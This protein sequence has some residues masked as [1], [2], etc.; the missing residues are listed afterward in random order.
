MHDLAGRGVLK[1]VELGRLTHGEIGQ[2]TL[3]QRRVQPQHLPGRDDPVAPER[4]REPRHSRIRI[5]PGRQVGGQQGDVGPRLVQPVV[6]ARTARPPERGPPA[7]PNAHGQPRLYGVD[8]VSRLVRRVAPV[9]PAFDIEVAAL[10]L[11][12]AEH[13]LGP[14]AAQPGGRFGKGQTTGPSHRVQSDIGEGHPPPVVCRRLC[15]P[16]LLAQRA[17]HL[18]DVGEVCGEV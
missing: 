6:E 17:A 2:H 12:Q 3:G 11:G 5:R 1:G 16:A 7:P 10:A 4:R 9:R 8:P 18:E 13:E 15:G 14:R